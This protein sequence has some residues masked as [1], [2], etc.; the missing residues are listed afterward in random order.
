MCYSSEASIGAFIFS[1][2]L[3]YILYKRKYIDVETHVE[4]SELEVFRALSQKIADKFDRWYKHK[5][6]TAN[7]IDEISFAVINGTNID[8]RMCFALHSGKKYMLP[9]NTARR[10]W[11]SG[12]CDLNVWQKPSYRKFFRPIGK[13]FPS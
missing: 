8:P 9:G 10:L 1:S 7:M 6:L 13:S 11:R 12:Y 4:L 2:I 5:D 3:S